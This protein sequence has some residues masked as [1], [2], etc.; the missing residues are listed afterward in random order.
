MGEEIPK[1]EDF[2][3]RPEEDF[4]IED[5]LDPL[6]KLVIL[7]K[8]GI[9]FKQFNEDDK[10]RFIKDFFEQKI[11]NNEYK[12]VQ[13]FI[14]ELAI[15]SSEDQLSIQIVQELFKRYFDKCIK[16]GKYSKLQDLLEEM[17]Y[18]SSDSELTADTIKTCQESSI[19]NG[20]KYETREE[21]E[22]AIKKSYQI[23]EL[24]IA[25]T[26]ELIKDCCEFN[27]IQGNY[28]TL[29]AFYQDVLYS[30]RKSDILPETL[31]YLVALLF[32]RSLDSTK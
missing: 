30:R 19:F 23:N 17:E 21:L 9:I 16:S 3:E 24:I 18:C 29:D 31:E 14:Y 7:L 6:S 5:Q 22:N 8:A 25:T 20:V 11:D 10:I 12:H 32:T 13:E 1:D 27:I 15:L 26:R 28:E 2:E 4:G